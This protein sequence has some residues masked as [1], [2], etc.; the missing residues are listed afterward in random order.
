MRWMGSQSMSFPLDMPTP[1][2][3]SRR[4]PFLHPGSPPQCTPFSPTCPTTLRAYGGP[5]A[6]IP[7]MPDHAAFTRP[8]SKRSSSSSADTPPPA[9]VSRHS[10]L[11]LAVISTTD[12]VKEG[13][14]AHL[15]VITKHRLCVQFLA[16]CR[17]VRRLLGEIVLGRA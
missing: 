12:S 10:N 7:N 1:L 3:S 8:L 2:R 11:D 5:S 6:G 9:K 14:G 16:E 17:R 4:G 15:D 13:H